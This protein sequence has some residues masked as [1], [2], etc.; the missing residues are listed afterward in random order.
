MNDTPAG[1]IF[2]K[3]NP[4]ARPGRPEWCVEVAIGDDS[5]VYVR[6]SKDHGKGPVLAFLDAEWQA[7]IIGMKSGEFDLPSGR[8]A[9]AHTILDWPMEDTAVTV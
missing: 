5:H 1:L 4:T 9:T 3:A 7:F 6:D 2:F 8:T